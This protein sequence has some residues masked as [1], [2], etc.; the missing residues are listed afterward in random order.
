MTASRLR[1]DARIRARRQDVM[2]QR[3]RRRRRVIVSVVV[4]VALAVAGTALAR[5][6]LFAIVDVRVAGV[7]GQE[8]DLVRRAAAIRPGNNLLSADL[9]AAAAR[10]ADLPW[11]RSATARRI[12]PSTVQLHVTR[13]EPVVVVRLPD[14]AWLVDAEGVVVA[15]GSQEGLVEITAPH[16]VVPGV[17]GEVR[18]AALRNALVA[19]AELPDALRASVVRY[20][21]PSARDLRLHLDGGVVVRFGVAE[22]VAEKARSVALLLEQVRSQAERRSATAEDESE[23]TG[24]DAMEVDVRAPANPVLVPSAPATQGAQG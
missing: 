9:G 19:R 23:G 14:A 6:S 7:Q 1:M 3:A 20:E 21:A 22:Q 11:I 15:G 8:A 12:P 16:S 2:R 17:G 4:V 5:S 10:A 18:D 24:F 13:R